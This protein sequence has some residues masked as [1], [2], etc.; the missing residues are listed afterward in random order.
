[1]SY[2]TQ[3]PRF[4][5][6]VLCFLL[7]PASLAQE[8]VIIDTDVAVTVS[9][10]E[11]QISYTFAGQEGQA[12]R[13]DLTALTP[14]MAPLFFVGAPD[15]SLVRA[16]GNPN[17]L[18]AITDTFT[19]TATGNFSITVGSWNQVYGLLALRISPAVADG[20]ATS[21]VLP[22]SCP[23]I[24]DNALDLVSN[25]CSL[26]GRNQA[27]LGSLQVN[28][29]FKESAIAARFQQ[30]GD[31]ANVTD[32]DTLNI[33][34][35]NLT[36][37]TWGVALLKVQANLPDTQ[38]GQN[39]TMLVFGDV[40]L[41][42]AGGETAGNTLSGTANTALN[43]RLG[44]GEGFAIFEIIAP[45][46]QVTIDGRANGGRW[47]RL[48]R[49]TGTPVWIVLGGVSITG[50]VNSLPLLSGDEP[51]EQFGP[52]Q[53][54]YFRSGI[55]DAPCIEAPDSGILIQT[56]QGVGKVDLL[57]NDV[58][59]S[60]GSTAFISAQPN[61]SLVIGTLEGSATVS[62]QG[63]TQIAPAGTQVQVLMD[64]NL[65][66]IAPPLPVE[67]LNL[68]LVKSV[69]VDKLPEPVTI[70]Q[71]IQPP[72]TPEGLVLP[73]MPT[74]GTCVVATL[75]AVNVNIRSGPGLEF[76]TVG[77]G[78][79]PENLYTVIGRTGDSSWWQI[80]AGWVAAEVT[81]R[82]GDCT[83][84]P[85]TYTPPTATPIPTLVPTITPTLT[86][87]LYPKY[88]LITD[89]QTQVSGSGPYQITA[90]VN[91]QQTD[92]CVYEVQRLVEVDTVRSI[93]TIYVDIYRLMP[94]DVICQSVV[95]PYQATFSVGSNFE[96]GDYYIVVNDFSVSFKVP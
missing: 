81:R 63:G 42:N 29:V 10:T 20:G 14:G 68:D 5:L 43:A 67:P 69:P 65:K 4:L 62:A 21:G 87:P 75:Q 31:I 27:C 22:G 56:P 93:T 11:P 49:D 12:I 1:M 15:G 70:P 8:Q 7:I 66:A 92:G 44:P 95:I 96:A 61:N 55:G 53:A 13:V 64:A 82:G 94:E 77:G 85:I 16:N 40:E 52:M 78:M 28:A 25:S 71:A 60:L 58:Q 6:L 79:N 41:Q 88:H 35:M 54:F 83:R 48:R 18:G 51:L 26:T 3:F 33:S 45:G 73:T 91:G 59:V 34:P 36:N 39:V 37:G 47:I 50:D 9:S 17:A 2:P 76:A 90:I 24:V 32:F 86:G 72:P 80:A 84:V 89:V 19:L 46:E 30:V 38:P 74:S 23:A 57:V